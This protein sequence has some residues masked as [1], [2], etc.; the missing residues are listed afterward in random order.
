LYRLNYYDVLEVKKT[1]TEEEIKNAYRKLALKYHPD[2]NSNLES[3]Q[4]F[5]EITEAKELLLDSGKRNV[6]DYEY[7]EGESFKGESSKHSDTKYQYSQDFSQSYYYEE[8]DEGN[9]FEEV[10]NEIRE[11][12]CKTLDIFLEVIR[13]FCS[14]IVKF[15]LRREF[16]SHFIEDNIGN[17]MHSIIQ[18]CLWKFEKIP[19]DY[20]FDYDNIV[21]K[22]EIEYYSNQ[23]KSELTSLRGR[24]DD[25]SREFRGGRKSKW[26][27]EKWVQENFQY[28][29]NYNVEDYAI[30]IKDK[31][32]SDIEKSIAE[33]FKIVRDN[34]IKRNNSKHYVSVGYRV[35]PEQ[36]P[37]GAIQDLPHWRKITKKE[38]PDIHQKMM[39]EVLL[40]VNS[41][42]KIMLLLCISI[43]K[44]IKKYQKSKFSK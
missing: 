30:K 29:K 18:N 43:E 44:N 19:D 9:N 22:L 10:A 8:E 32:K 17:Y 34:E 16:N 39:L 40:H 41:I 38:I 15:D 3:H 26:I 6:Y 33:Y 1:A 42:S 21:D 35:P 27:P 36:V 12:T 7:F 11:I 13:V 24:F 23:I 4:Q 31:I 25:F 2:R 20:T 5:I 28:Q 37:E 14:K